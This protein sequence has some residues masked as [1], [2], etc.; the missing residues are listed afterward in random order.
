MGEEEGVRFQVKFAAQTKAGKDINK[1]TKT[2]QDAYQ[3]LEGF[4]E[5]GHIFAVFDGHGDDGEYV[6]AA[7]R[8]YMHQILG[9]YL[10]KNVDVRL[11][12]EKTFQK[13]QQFIELRKDIK[14]DLSGSTANLIFI[15]NQNVNV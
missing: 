10:S 7:C 14:A 9:N 6:S 11:S 3:T 12:L 8:Q 2:N 15:D 1:N 4:L 13:T 5:T